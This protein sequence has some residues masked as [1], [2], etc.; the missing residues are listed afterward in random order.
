VIISRAPSNVSNVSATSATGTMTVSKSP[1]AAAA[2][3]RRTASGDSSELRAAQNVRSGALA[4]PIAAAVI[5]TTTLRQISERGRLE[6][7]LLP[8]RTRRSIKE[9]G[10]YHHT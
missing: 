1:S 3:A 5:S 6:D 10:M 9:T 8:T 4:A 7:A 2:I